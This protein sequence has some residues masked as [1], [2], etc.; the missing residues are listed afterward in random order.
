[1]EGGGGGCYQLLGTGT[2]LSIS[3]INLSLATSGGSRQCGGGGGG[4]RQIFK[5]LLLYFP[6]SPIIWII[7]LFSQTGT[8]LNEEFSGSVMRTATSQAD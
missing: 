3:H 8:K 4:G 1:M 5:I 7:F 2:S 6:I